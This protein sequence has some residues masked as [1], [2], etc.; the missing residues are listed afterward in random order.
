[1]VGARYTLVDVL[2]SGGM[3]T[4]WRATDEVL[5]REVAVK[6]LS[7][8]LAADWA[9]RDRFARE[10]KHAAALSHPRL[11][12]VYD[13]GEDGATPYIVMELVAGP[14][15]RQVLDDAGRLAP[16]DAIGI[17][18]AVC[19]ALEAAHQAG[20]VHRDIKPAN[21]VLSPAGV[22]VLDFGIARLEGAA[23]G[24]RTL[25]VLGTAAYLAPEVASG[26]PACPRSDLYSLGCVLFEMLTGMP[27]FTGDADVAVA[28]RHVH[29]DP[30]PPSAL[31]PGLPGQLDWVTTQLLAKR[32]DERPPDA[33]AARAGLLAALTPGRTV[34]LP[35]QPGQPTAELAEPARRVRRPTKPELVL[36]ALL[37]ACLAGLGAAVGSL[38]N[39]AG[40]PNRAQR[41]HHPSVAS[42]P[43][44]S[45]PASSPR[46]RSFTPG[47]FTPGGTN[48]TLPKVA[49]A[50]GQFVAVLEAGMASGQVSQQAGQ[51]L[52]NQLSQL[53]SEPPGQN[54][55][56][57]QQRYYQLV[58]K[59]GQDRVNGQIN[60]QAA[61]R[62]AYALTLL[63]QAFGVQ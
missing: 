62:L 54:Q 58:Q 10:A 13:C 45:A 2:G 30:G 9:F 15:L 31:R 29:D 51:D 23:G 6:M 41:S 50:A 55:Q 42:H 57:A 19:E 49:T 11:V 14:T 59:Y 4:V 39:G 47:S 5:D 26:R 24:T 52:L 61:T 22:K 18:A 48:G 25:A 8:Q 36:S 12:T 34:V 16:D 7:P 37:I 63:R 43:S 21:I 38:G 3:A 44:T 56:Q 33:A 20:L 28:Y 46:P 35:P 1:M 60:A 27:P 32:P 17:A 40:T 53:L